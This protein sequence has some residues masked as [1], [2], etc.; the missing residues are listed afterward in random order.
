MAFHCDLIRCKV[1]VQIIRCH[2]WPDCVSIVLQAT[3]AAEQ[4]K[5]NTATADEKNRAKVGRVP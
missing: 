5:Q 1:L 3:P 4:P 2:P